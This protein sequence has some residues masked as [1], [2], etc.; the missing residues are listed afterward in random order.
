M[1]LVHQLDKLEQGGRDEG[2]AL[3]HGCS[4]A[5]LWWALCAVSSFGRI[6]IAQALL[7]RLVHRQSRIG[8]RVLRSTRD[9]PEGFLPLYL[10][11][12]TAVIS[13]LGQPV[14]PDHRLSWVMTLAVLGLGLCVLTEPGVVRCGLAAALRRHRRLAL[15]AP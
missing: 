14:H 9:A 4:P 10:L 1:R 2:P 8:C 7:A 5:F 15:S 3:I 13:L 11:P 12:L 6:R